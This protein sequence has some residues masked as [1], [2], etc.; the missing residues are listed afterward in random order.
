MNNIISNLKN[1]TSENIDLRPA[2]IEHRKINIKEVVAIIKNEKVLRNL[3]L[4]K[5]ND[6][7]IE[8][9]NLSIVY[10]RV[11]HLQ[12]VFK[13][14][15]FE[16]DSKNVTSNLLILHEKN[17]T[18]QKYFQFN[19][20]DAIE[21][22]Q[23][24]EQDVLHNIKTICIYNSFS[25]FYDNRHLTKYL[26]SLLEVGD[27]EKIQDIND[28]WNKPTIINQKSYKKVFRTVIDENGNYYLKSINSPNYKEYDI[29]CIF[30]LSTIGVALLQQKSNSYN[31][32]I[33]RCRI[34]E[35]EIDIFYKI[36]ESYSND[37]C[38]IEPVIR[39]RSK[40][41]RE[42]SIQ[43]QF[44]L[45]VKS[46]DGMGDGIDLYPNI[47]QT[48]NLTFYKQ[49]NHTAAEDQIVQTFTNLG[50]VWDEIDTVKNDITNIMN[51]LN[52]ADLKKAIEI[53]FSNNKN[54]LAKVKQLKEFFTKDAFYAI[55]NLK[56]LL[57]YCGK[58]KSLGISF[59]NEE[60]MIIFLS[61]LLLDKK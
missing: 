61:N 60:R 35:G 44:I 21:I 30:A 14:V 24:H 19:I 45:N 16:V 7:D 22:N 20:K 32:T 34:S 6:I 26:K 54:T 9:E 29:A 43:R 38:I 13:L 3:E 12:D 37:H 42:H 41:D 47:K 10:D 40:N 56:S 51:S 59:E 36:K 11:K 5:L 1:F 46:L 28:S 50:S 23:L 52:V 17:K 2:N 48:K 49:Y 4:I 53:H 8:I 25:Q 33:T 58:I 31:I 18:P 55:E 57:D 39:V 15:K 27:Q